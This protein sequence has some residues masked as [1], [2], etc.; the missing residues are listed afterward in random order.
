MIYLIGVRHDIQF[1][2]APH[3]AKIVRD[4]RELYKARVLEVI[5]E[6]G[7]SVLAEEFNDEG[8]KK[9][10]VSETTLEQIAKAKGIEHRFC[11]P[12]AVEKTENEI[13]K[14]DFDK[15]E[16]FWLSRIQDC[17]YKNVLFVCGDDHFESFGKK[18]SAAGFDVK[19]GLRLDIS[20]DDVWATYEL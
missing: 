4:K 11:E 3:V 8:K 5:K 7:I 15:R 2:P 6:F 1:D 14:S 12:T 17:K 13:E 9:W 20:D 10:R 16:R 19:R 18:L